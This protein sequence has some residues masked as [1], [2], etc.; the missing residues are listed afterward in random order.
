M[1]THGYSHKVR[2]LQVPPDDTAH[3]LVGVGKVLQWH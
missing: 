1:Q 2:F 3:E